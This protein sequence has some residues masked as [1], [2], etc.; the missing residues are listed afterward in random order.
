S[1]IQ[2][3][4]ALAT[5]MTSRQGVEVTIGGNQAYSQGGR[6]NLPNGDFTD[7]EWVAMIQGWI[8]HELGHEKHTDHNIFASSGKID[9]ALQR[10]L[11]QVED[12]RMEKCVGDE[13]PGARTNLSQL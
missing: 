6:I 7:P 2:R 1:F 12:A 5:L 10:I 13:F 11:N 4:K 3:A 8:D 9:P